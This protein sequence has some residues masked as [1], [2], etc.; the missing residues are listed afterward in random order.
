MYYYYVKQLLS[1]H[2]GPTPLKFWKLIH[3]RLISYR[4]NVL[5]LA[6]NLGKDKIDFTAIY[7]AIPKALLMYKYR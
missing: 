4:Q 5:V 6:N 1:S 2:I 7:I 3:K